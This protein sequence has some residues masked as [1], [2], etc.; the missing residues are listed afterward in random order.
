MK[1]NEVR[2]PVACRILPELRQQLELEAVKEG[3]S[4]SSYMELILMRR[5]AESTVNETS[6]EV[7]KAM[8][9]QI[10]ELKTENERLKDLPKPVNL[11]L[12]TEGI[13]AIK[14]QLGQTEKQYQDLMQRY[15]DLK[16]ERDALP[17]APAVN[18]LPSWWSLENYRS[19]VTYLKELKSKHPNYSTEQLLLSALAVTVTNENNWVEVYTLKD[20]W[21][22]NPHFLNLQTP[23]A[24]Q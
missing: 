10:D 6:N 16:V 5:S 17:K 15:K 11:E 2:T 20:F 19:T 13:T 4:L 3:H 8:Q 1:K 24:K 22:R 12:D 21:K 18:G 23:T 7:F 9:K 14:T